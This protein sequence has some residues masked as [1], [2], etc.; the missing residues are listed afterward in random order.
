MYGQVVRLKM[1]TVMAYFKLLT[2]HLPEATKAD[3]SEPKSR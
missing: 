1:K 3:D 2:L